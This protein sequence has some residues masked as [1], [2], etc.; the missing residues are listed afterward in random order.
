MIETS[1]LNYLMVY[2]KSQSDNGETYMYGNFITNN[3]KYDIFDKDYLQRYIPEEDAEFKGYNKDINYIFLKANSE[4]KYFYLSIIS[5]N[6]NLIELFIN[7]YNHYNGFI[8]NP[9]LMQLFILNQETK[10]EI[11]LNF[12]SK[13]A[14][15]IST[16]ILKGEGE[17]SFGNK[18][19]NLNE[20]NNKILFAFNSDVEE[21]LTI[22]NKAEKD[23]IFYIEYYLRNSTINFEEVN[24]EENPIIDYKNEDYPL[25]LCSKMDKSFNHD[26][27]IFFNFYNLTLNNDSEKY[28]K[29]KELKISILLEKEKDK[30][31]Y[32]SLNEIGKE[33]YS[34]IIGSYD[35][36]ISTGQINIPKDKINKIISSESEDSNYILTIEKNGENKNIIYKKISMK[37]NFIKE[38]SGIPIVENKYHFGKIFDENII[39]KYKLK[40]DKN[41]EYIML[42]FSANSKI[43]NYNI[44]KKEDNGNENEMILKEYE[45][46]EENGKI[47]TKYKISKDFDYLY[48]NVFMVNTLNIKENLNKLNNYVFKYNNIKNNDQIF[49][50][51]IL[52]SN[53]KLICTITENKGNRISIKV[54]YNKVKKQN[55]YE[56]IY[57]LRI[58]KK[59]DL[60]EGELYDTIAITESNSYVFQIKKT[61]IDD[62]NDVIKIPLESFNE[63]NFAYIEL[64]AQIID[65]DNIEYIAYKPIKSL[66]EIIFKQEGKSHA[67]A[68]TISI[69]I[70]LILIIIA[71]IIILKFRKQKSQSDDEVLKQVEMS[72]PIEYDDVLMERSSDIN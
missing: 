20:K 57:S 19:Y 66:S 14:I 13:N 59:K 40:I 65:G 61:Y 45:K 6:S 43:V 64:I 18:G 53:T 71:A 60:I 51:P 28:V 32:I 44:T 36:A 34:K 27:N 35:P 37:T 21:I 58:V 39:N 29:N 54:S 15:M 23:F 48:L 26:I 49:Q 1:N 33:N 17:L 67:F 72:S 8:P 69:I 7:F 46:K 63:K 31:N 10:N 56:V 11:N 68:I 16:V 50:Y 38:N 62:K 2:A 41:A 12:L 30:Y 25:F 55:N 24:I 5:N 52:N 42:K 9:N 3:E 22:K 4:K 47:I 70:I